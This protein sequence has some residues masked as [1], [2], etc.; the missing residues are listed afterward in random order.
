MKNTLKT[1]RTL[2]ALDRSRRGK[3]EWL[4]AKAY[5][6]CTFQYH[7]LCVAGKCE[8][9]GLTEYCQAFQDQESA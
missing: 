7:T 2:I 4:R 9:T 5:V 8:I 6:E 3:A 1:V